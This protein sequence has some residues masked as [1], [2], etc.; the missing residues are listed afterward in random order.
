LTRSQSARGLRVALFSG[1]YNCFRDGANKAL[2]RL[3]RYLLDR[4][5]AVRV[6]SPTIA[7]PPFE[8]AGELVSVPSIAMPRR[9]EIRLGLGLPA[10]VERNVRE[11]EPNLVHVS[12]PD[13]LDFGAQRLARKLGVPVVASMH[14]HFEAYFDF[15]GLGA[16]KGWAVER[17]RKFYCASDRVLA[18]TPASKAH[19]EAM[20]VPGDRIR[21][22][23]RG[24]EHETFNPARRSE[25]WRR[26]QGCTD[27]DLILLFFGRLVREKG[28]AEFIATVGE[29]R[30]RSRKVRP[31]IVGDGPGRGEFTGVGECVMTGELHGDAL[32]QAVASADILLNPSMTEV[33]GNVNLEAMAAGLAVVSSNAPSATGLITNGHDGLLRTPDPIAF[34]DAIERLWVD[35]SLRRALRVNAVRTAQ[36]YRWDSVNEQALDAYREVYGTSTVSLARGS[37]SG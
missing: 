29:L 18:P 13:W 4:G 11:F 19:L 8:P 35:P 31:L 16:L 25:E 22:W 3:V 17:Q 10:S 28:I 33:F 26:A 1:N 34:A 2:N 7:K 24:V 20:G 15:Y 36:D 21:I 23:A 30:R 14:S 27:R 32:A 6:Y 37:S 5:A 9:P 12:A